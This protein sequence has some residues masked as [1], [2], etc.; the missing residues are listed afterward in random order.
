MQCIYKIKKKLKPESF[1]RYL[2][3]GDHDVF[4]KLTWASSSFTASMQ[5]F[6]I[7]R[8]RLPKWNV[9]KK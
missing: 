6:E 8:E 3:L 5:L 4:H 2:K 1:F 9:T 7:A